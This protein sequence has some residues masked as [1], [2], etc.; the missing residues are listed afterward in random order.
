[1]SK[2]DTKAKLAKVK[3]A[4]AEKCDRLAA[5]SGSIPKQK[6]YKRQAAKFRRQAADLTR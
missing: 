1:M 5:V 4:L 6:T 2:A 3:V